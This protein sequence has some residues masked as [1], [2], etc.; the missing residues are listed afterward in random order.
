MTLNQSYI[1]SLKDSIRKLESIKHIRPLSILEYKELQRLY[2]ELD[3]YDIS[4]EDSQS[5]IRGY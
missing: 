2:N 5:Y 3:C 4:L 1:S